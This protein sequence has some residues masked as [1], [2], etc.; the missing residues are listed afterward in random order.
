MIVRA[1]VET[2]VL[3][4]ELNG[5]LMTPEEFDAV[6][7]YDELYVYELIRGVLIVNPIPLP[8]ERGPNGY[9]EHLLWSYAEDHPQG[10]SL[11][12]TLFEHY[13]RTAHSRR[14]ADRVIWA[15]L[16][17]QPKPNSD[18]PSVAIEFVS[19]GRRNWLRDYVEKRDEYMALGIAEYW[20]VNRFERTM[21]VFR[22]TNEGI[23]ELVLRENEV[24]R[25]ALL[26]GFELP[27]GRLL[28]AADRWSV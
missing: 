5:V 15:G 9:L 17:R 2:F 11:D 10:A 26:P 14:R 16:G 20:V 6:E 3:G 27:I 12:A 8:E 21:T 28:Q 18:V 22:R 7:E 25:P 23:A 19:R 24:Y 4:P 1:P 13:I